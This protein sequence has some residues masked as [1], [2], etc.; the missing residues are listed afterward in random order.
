MSK[1]CINCGEQLD[2]NATYCSKC[3]ALQKENSKS[4]IKS[5]TDVAV[6]LK[7]KS[8][9]F[10][11]VAAGIGVIIIVLIIFNLFFGNYKTPIKNFYNGFEDGSWKKISSALP[12][13]VVDIFENEILDTQHLLG[14]NGMDEYVDQLCDELKNQYG[15]NFKIK[16][17]YKDK[18]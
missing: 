16:V 8:S 14:M 10:K 5:V 3:G 18:D 12:E 9:I 4:T 17:K 13:D 15:D 7:S 1:F 6:S 2:D 11:V